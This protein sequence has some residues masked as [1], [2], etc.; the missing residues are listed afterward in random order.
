LAKS[1]DPADL[2]HA[3]TVIELFED[4]NDDDDDYMIVM[5]ILCFFVREKDKNTKG[6]HNIMVSA[7]TSKSQLLSSL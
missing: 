4:D 5:A 3:V 6:N 2:K 7:M 1:Q